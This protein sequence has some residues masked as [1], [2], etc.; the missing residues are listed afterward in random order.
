M[1]LMSEA[2]WELLALAGITW[3]VLVLVL[4]IKLFNRADGIN[5]QLASLI[6][7][8]MGGKSEND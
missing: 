8:Q 6:T 5:R 7:L 4:L 3:R 2:T 1:N